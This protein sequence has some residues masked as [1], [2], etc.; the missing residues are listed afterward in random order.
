M[1]EITFC[2][3][4]CLR[5]CTAMA[6]TFFFRVITQNQE[7]KKTSQFSQMFLSASRLQKKSISSKE[8]FKRALEQRRRWSLSW[9]TLALPHPSRISLDR[10]MNKEGCCEQIKRFCFAEMVGKDSIYLQNKLNKHGSQEFQLA[11]K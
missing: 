1:F 9:K 6:T 11:K 10:W 5:A 7:S 4:T 8:T 2:L 3:L